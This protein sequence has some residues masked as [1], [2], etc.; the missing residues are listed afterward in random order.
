MLETGGR[1]KGGR[2]GVRRNEPL[3][4][5][6]RDQG[7]GDYGDHR[8]RTIRIIEEVGGWDHKVVD[9]RGHRDICGP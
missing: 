8:S 1:G 6:L 3:K 2:Q 7:E 5:D 4:G 9:H